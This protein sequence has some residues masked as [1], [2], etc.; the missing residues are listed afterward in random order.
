MV[1][2]VVPW[3]IRNAVELH[4]FVPLSTG[5]GPTMCPSRNPEATGGF[6]IGLRRTPVPAA[7]DPTGTNV[8][9]G[10]GRRP[11]PIRDP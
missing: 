3:T 4:A 7:K 9:T 8:A 1:V 10:G 11:V 5:V 6:D 2:V